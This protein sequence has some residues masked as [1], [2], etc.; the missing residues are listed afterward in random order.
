MKKILQSILLLIV[1]LGIGAF[2]WS[3]ISP[4]PVAPA[5]PTEDARTNSSND[6]TTTANTAQSAAK[7]PVV[8]TYFTTDVRC[9]S[10][11]KIERL[12]LETLERDFAGAME[13]GQLRFQTINID[14]LENKHYARDYKLA[15]KTVVVSQRSPSGRPLRHRHRPARRNRRH[16]P[17]AQCRNSQSH[18][19][20]NAALSKRR[21]RPDW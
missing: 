21:R 16:R 8:V 11:K 12:T 3:K 7:S 18:P 9:V 19:Q 15:F 2:V 10:C 4:A 6:A 5:T 20:P 13:S 17:C 1:A 14:R